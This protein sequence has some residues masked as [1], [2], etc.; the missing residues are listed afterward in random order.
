M[1]DIQKVKHKL[2]EYLNHYDINDQQIKL[3]IEHIYRVSDLSKRLAESLGLREDDII[4]AE[5]IGLL[6]DIGRFEQIKRYHTF[7]DK[8][9]LDHGE[10]GCKILFEDGL[11]REFIDDTSYDRIIRNAIINHNRPEINHVLKGNELFHSKIIR[12]AD[13]TDILYLSTLSDQVNTVYGSNKFK[14][15]KISDSVYDDFIK[16]RKVD[17]NHIQTSADVVL[18]H[19]AYIFDYNFNELLKYILDKE[20]LDR[21]YELVHFDDVLSEMRFRDCYLI[22]REYIKKKVKN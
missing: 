21:I 3:K 9:S 7:I 6:H 20:Y 13:K 17:Y 19:L 2:K 12:D 10:F 11:I 22:T 8:D 14:S 18:C 16:Y 1:I 15:E 4:L 5:V